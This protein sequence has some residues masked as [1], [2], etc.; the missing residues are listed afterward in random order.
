MQAP[1]FQAPAI[2]A[3]P[4]GGLSRDQWRGLVDIV[5]TESPR[6]GKSLAFGRVLRAAAGEVVVAFTP[7][8]DFHRA[9][10]SGA[11]RNLIEEI[12]TRSFGT[13]TRLVIDA[14]GAANAP[15]SLAEEEAKEREAHE[16]SVEARVRRHPSLERAM[17]LLGGEIEHIQIV[18]RDRTVLPA[19]DGSD[20]PEPPEPDLAE[21]AS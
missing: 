20:A 13:P 9:T 8:A 2:S 14:H 10:V 16:K 15:P 7:E 17:R 21:D 5:R 19:G 4:G 12:L 11:G 3:R 1:S 6:H 18:E